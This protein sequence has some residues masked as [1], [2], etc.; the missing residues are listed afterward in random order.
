MI[1]MHGEDFQVSL[2]SLYQKG[3]KF[4][5]SAEKV[6]SL[7]GRAKLGG[8]GIE[9]VFEGIAITNYGENRI[10][11]CVK[12]DLT[13]F[14]R[15]V[16]VVNN[17]ICIFLYVGDHD[18]VQN[19]CEKNR[20]LD[21][22]AKREGD[23]TVI[24]TV[25]VSPSLNTPIW[26]E[27]D[28][29]N[30][31]LVDLLPKRYLAKILAS[32]DLDVVDE[33]CSIE[34]TDDDNL[35]LGIC[36]RCGEPRQQVVVM[37]VILS[38][39]SGD[40]SNA[41]T[42]IDIFTTE[43]QPVDHLSEEMVEKL[44][45][46]DA[47]VLLQ[48][49][50]SELFQHFVQTA[51]FEKW[52]LYLHPAQ[53]KHA[54]QDHSGAARM[55]GV[56]GSG[57]TCVIVHRALRLAEKYT[58]QPIL[59][60]TLSNALTS[61]I[62]QLID[63]QRGHLRPKNL[64][65][66]SIFDL[67]FEKLMEFEPEKKDYYTKRSITRNPHAI[68]EHIDEV[69]GE[70]IR[71]ENNVKAADVLLE[72]VQTLNARSVYASAYIRQEFDFI[73]SSS[74]GTDRS[75]YLG[76]ERHGRTVPLDEKLRS[77][78]LAGLS[79]WE[80]KM[81]DVGV[82]DDMGI[83]A[84]LHKHWGQLKPEYRCILVD[85]VQ[86]LGTLELSI[87]RRL[88]SE[89]DNDIFLCGDAAQTI[90]TKSSDLKAAGINIIGRSARLNQNYRNSRQ[91][92]TA[93]HSVLTN[94]L[95]AMPTGSAKVDDVMAPEFASFSSPKPLLLK[96]SSLWD[97]L[98][99]GLRFLQD[100]SEIESGNQRYCLAVCGFSQASIEDLGKSLGMPI[101]SGATDVRVGKIFLSDLEQT[102]GFEF[103]AVVVV[104][105]TDGVM[106]HP[107]LPAEESFRDLCR[108]YVA[109][110]RAK[111][112]LVI[113]YSGT[114]SRFIAGAIDAFVDSSLADYAEELTIE[115][116][117]LPPAALPVLYDQVYW[118]GDGRLF[119]KSRDAVGL[120]RVLQSEILEHVP[121]REVVRG[122]KQVAWKT[123]SS[124]IVAMKEPRIRHL[125]LSD[126]AWNK[127]SQH[128]DFL[129]ANVNNLPIDRQLPKDSV[130]TLLFQ[131]GFRKILIEFH[132]SGGS[133]VLIQ[134][135]AS[136]A[137]SRFGLQWTNST[138][139][140]LQ[141]M[142]IQRLLHRIVKETNPQPGMPALNTWRKFLEYSKLAAQDNR[143]IN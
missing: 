64:V 27:S 14:A 37:D 10:P 111:T 67:C 17:G 118:Q 15:L 139:T 4:Q 137:I 135:A 124:F 18:K 16:T 93:A 30:G 142:E 123:F 95:E 96:A 20:G 44:I 59:V 78:I 107:G 88:T 28:L 84:A 103:D 3:G 71:C 47:A 129:K 35:I 21:F 9:D 141:S 11:H 87:I 46:G 79:G 140:D 85:E 128:V 130:G 117:Q 109:M 82:I 2:R 127:L 5:K 55:L 12:Y 121:G 99:R 61:L 38:L 6:Q 101:L 70:Y 106:P 25:R 52:M 108:L 65:V 76:M 73:R 102:K 7:W 49:V 23:N 98:S 94:A 58:G 132:S 105:C 136:V 8:A 119:L 42:C 75:S 92:L 120:D 83:V 122:K 56:S 81:A 115:E 131:E 33:I 60:V 138:G 40:V 1:F 89:D 66:K 31:P 32:L 112:Q 80:K 69:W 63:S 36:G 100:C 90:Y 143:I 77:T 86:D 133:E 26:S 13:G 39:R 104:N 48:D 68:S 72:F 41:K 22:V 134:K 29:T 45:S 54:E 43:A 19:W 53:R 113:T 62:D 50:D 110:T 125:I 116:F 51:S 74:G 126:E 91:I 57:K 97:E 24:D 114:P 34:S